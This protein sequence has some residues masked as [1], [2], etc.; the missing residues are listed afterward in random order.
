[1]TAVSGDL[2]Q[3][4]TRPSA[5]SDGV[6]HTGVEAPAPVL[7][8]RLT[9]SSPKTRRSRGYGAKE[10]GVLESKASM[11]ED[12]MRLRY[13]TFSARF[14]SAKTNATIGEAWLLLALEMSRL[15]DKA[16]STEQC[17]NK[18]KW[19]KR[20]WAEYNSDM[21]ATGNLELPVVEP[22]GLALMLEYWASSS[23][24]NG[25]TLA[26][27]EEDTN[28]AEMEGNTSGGTK[29]AETVPTI[30]AQSKTRKTMADS[31]DVGMKSMAD[32]FQAMAAAM[33]TTAPHSATGDIVSAIDQR[34]E[35][36]M[37]S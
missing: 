23:G 29:E 11:V 9:P 15:H 21:R 22:P 16:I 37:Q 2:P 18:V 6:A 3:Q 33:T 34:F 30:T 27:N 32:S 13:D 35:A 20:K 17:K 5:L 14:G 24:M 19:L 7:P 12:L 31:F 28:T 26:D 8:A 25:Q 10:N 4:P 36:M 1:M